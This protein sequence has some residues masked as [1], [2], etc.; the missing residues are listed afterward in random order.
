MAFETER[1]F[2]QRPGFQ[3]MSCVDD[4]NRRSDGVHVTFGLSVVK[5]ERK[6]VKMG[7]ADLEYGKL[8]EC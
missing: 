6:L 3:R 1:C 4:S 5:F 7:V 8:A 2:S